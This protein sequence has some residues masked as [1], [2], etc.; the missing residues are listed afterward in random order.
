[1][2]CGRRHGTKYLKTDKQATF[3]D[4]IDACGALVACHSVDYNQTSGAC[5]Y[6][7]R[8]G[9]PTIKAAEF[10]SAY[11]L[12]CNAACGRCGGSSGTVPAP[13]PPTKPSDK[14]DLS[15]E[16][17]GF[18]YAIY[19]NNKIDGTKNTFVPPDYPS[20][21]PTIFKKAHTEN[22][23]IPIEVIGQTKQVGFSQST[24]DIYDYKRANLEYVVVNHRGYLFAKEAGE[25][26]FSSPSADDGVLLWVGSEA[27]DG[28]DRENAKIVQFYGSPAATYKQSFKQGEYVPI[29]LMYMNAQAVA[30]FAFEITAPDGSVII[31]L[32]T[33][34]ESPYL[35]QYACEES[36]APKFPPY[37]MET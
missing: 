27:Y 19:P 34:E 32:D 10:S 36:L 7:N 8:F 25:Y 13:A 5:S 28:W 14:P 26:T 2:D 11:S 9:Q 20:F 24:T 6:G 21:D 30:V 1:M 23:N 4:C 16:N 18:Q 15:C 12:G 37:G 31:G 3:K 33:T 22:I 29:R 17:Q 35:V